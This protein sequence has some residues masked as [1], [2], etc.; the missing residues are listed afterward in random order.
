M[1]E[2][3]LELTRSSESGRLQIE[4][5]ESQSYRCCC[6]LSGQRE[7]ETRELSAA[8]RGAAGCVVLYESSHLAP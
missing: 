5:I 3:V 4:R 8:G 2:S 7:V 6:R 1:R